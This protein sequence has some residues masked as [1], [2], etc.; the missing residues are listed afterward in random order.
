MLIRP[1]KYIQYAKARSAPQLTKGAAD[2]IIWVYTSFCNDEAKGNQK[3]TSPLTAR[4][5]E[6]L[7]RLSTA[8]AKAHLSS[9]V[10]EKDARI[11][12]ETMRFALFKDVPKPERR[13][14]NHGVVGDAAESDTDSDRDTEPAVPDLLRKHPSKLMLALFRNRLARLLRTQF[15]E[16]AIPMAVLLPAINEGMSTGTLFGTAEAQVCALLMTEDNEIM[17]SDDAVYKI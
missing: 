16:E 4:T 14:L 13:K 11:A 8:H 7:I 6:T 12:E 17:L 2:W 15:G 9:K 3:K 10:E 1:E 5:L